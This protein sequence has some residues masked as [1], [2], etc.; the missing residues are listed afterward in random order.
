MRISDPNLREL[1]AAE[2]ALGMHT[3]R[4]RSRFARL[5]REDARLR[6]TI[7]EWEARFHPLV[8]ALPEVQPPARVWKAIQKRIARPV[9]GVSRA[10]SFWRSLALL[11]TAAAMALVVYIGVAPRP[12]AAPY[13]VSVMSTPEAQPMMVA[14]WQ[15][16]DQGELK[17]Q[18]LAKHVMTA[19]TS[20]E[21]WCLPGKNQ[22]PV[23]LGLITTDTVQTVKL[24]EKEMRELAKA[25]ALAMSVEPK[26]GSPTGLPTGPVLASGPLRKI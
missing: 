9:E 5:A 16:E 10:L 18:I 13:M 25:E 14:T 20:W 4:V 17:I 11:S 7:E 12:D 2:H 1:L 22:P 23:S 15:D 26:G 24:S 21:L 8:A 19:D 3:A 6:N